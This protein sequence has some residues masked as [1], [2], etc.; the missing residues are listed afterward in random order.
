MIRRLAI[1]L[2]AVPLLLALADTAS[3]QTPQPTLDVTVDR[4]A[5]FDQAGVATVTGTYT[6]TNADFADTIDITGSIRQ[7]FGRFSIVGTF[8]F[9]EQATSICDGTAR[10]W[11]A[12]AIPEN[13]IF[14]G[15][16]ATVIASGTACDFDDFQIPC[17][18]DF[19]EPETVQLRG[20]ST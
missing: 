1:A 15:G 2:M 7:P 13:G 20:G 19:G 3:A 18:I 17:A 6:C 11:S 5:T 9:I 14:R 4:F 8:A 16:K 10:S 12:V